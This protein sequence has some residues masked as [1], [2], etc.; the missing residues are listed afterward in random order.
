[1]G[2]H[3]FSASPESMWGAAFEEVCERIGL[4][5]AQSETRWLRSARARSRSSS[6]SGG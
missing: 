3:M 2:E 4:I 5:F 6:A 1:M